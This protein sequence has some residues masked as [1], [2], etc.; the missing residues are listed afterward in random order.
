MPL[1]QEVIQGAMAGLDFGSPEEININQQG[2]S[3]QKSIGVQC[4]QFRL[5]ET[6]LC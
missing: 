4:T 6:V 1:N 5:E 3:N 2:L